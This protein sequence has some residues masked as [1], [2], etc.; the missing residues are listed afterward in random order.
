MLSKEIDVDKEPNI[1]S[2]TVVV[3]D[4]GNPRLSAVVDIVIYV[5]GVDDNVPIWAPP[6]NGNYV[7]G[8]RSFNTF[9]F[10]HYNRITASSA[11]CY[12]KNVN[13]IKI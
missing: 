6:E 8:T 7:I 12:S 2:I 4:R 5:E 1:W 3:R 11:K 9:T 10:R 13:A